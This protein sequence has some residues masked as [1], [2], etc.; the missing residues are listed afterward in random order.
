[1]DPSLIPF[2]RSRT[3]YGESVTSE[4]RLL[5]TPDAVLAVTNAAGDVSYVEGADYVVDRSSRR[6][7]LPAGSRMAGTVAVT[8]THSDDPWTWRPIDTP[9]VLRRFTGRLKRG[10][11][12][13]LCLT[14][15]SISEGYDVSG[16][17]RVPPYQPAFGPLVASALGQ[18]YGAPVR[19]HNLGTAGWTAGDAVW[20]VARIVAPAPDM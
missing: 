13:T 18:Q 1:M 5:L 20:D 17:H 2:W 6:L 15:D 11:P 4:G 12:V 9:G 3:M 7:V 8:Y 16:L 14:G 19:L 10:E